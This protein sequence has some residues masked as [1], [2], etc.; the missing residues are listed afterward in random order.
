MG[1]IAG[2][3][4]G[5]L[6]HRSGVVVLSIPQRGAKI[7]L[8]S[9]SRHWWRLALDLSL[10]VVER[11]WAEFGFDASLL[12]MLLAA[13]LACTAPTLLLLPFVSLGM[14][15]PKSTRRVRVW[16]SILLPLLCLLFA[17]HYASFAG[18]D[19]LLHPERACDDGGAAAADNAPSHRLLRAWLGLEGIHLSS[20]V[21]LFLAMGAC[22]MQV[23]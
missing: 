6:S 12:L 19:A 20:L 21:A 14:T 22:V 8:P 17:L 11:A 18:W 9:S 5:A 2:A 15:N 13:C 7:E 10:G 1:P 23:S 4:G 3:A 16:R